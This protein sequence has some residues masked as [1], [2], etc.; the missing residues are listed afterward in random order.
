MLRRVFAMLPLVV[1]VTGCTLIVGAI[2]VSANPSIGEIGMTIGN[3]SL[4]LDSVALEVI[5][6]KAIGVN[7]IM[8]DKN[9]VTLDPFMVGLALVVPGAF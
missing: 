2:V 7:G 1:V 6:R 4:A 3:W 9:F 8:I 5:H